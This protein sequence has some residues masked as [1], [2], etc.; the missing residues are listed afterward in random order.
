M[1]G[2]DTELKNSEAPLRPGQRLTMTNQPKAGIGLWLDC[3]RVLAALAICYYHLGLF[4]P[5]P[6]SAEGEYAVA[7]FLLLAI[8]S[9]VAFSLPKHAALNPWSYL[10]A[11][12]GRLLPLYVFVNV[13]IYAASFFIPS[14]LG[15]PFTVIELVLSSLGLSQYFGHRYLSEVF[16]FVPFVIQVY[17]LIAFGHRGIERLRGWWLLPAAFVLYWLEILAAEIWTAHPHQIIRDWSPLL[18]PAEVLFSVQGGL[19]LTGRLPDR[20]FAGRLVLYT[21]LAG[22]LAALGAWQGGAGELTY[23]YM[24]PLHGLVV[25]LVILG[26]AWL[27]ARLVASDAAGWWRRLGRA[28]YPFYLIHGM[29]IAAIFHRFGASPGVWLG[30]LVVC[31]AAALTLDAVFSYRPRRRT[32]VP[33]ISPVS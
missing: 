31:V 8:S 28:T 21:A 27:C 4:L 17:V 32:A 23:L 6:L 29:A 7:T 10:G 33:S 16:W 24:L 1:R 9:A 13:S 2:V 14:K 25:S 18:R 5:L 15:R 20:A 12:L 11:R 3:A 19:W 26:A 22:I 30:Y